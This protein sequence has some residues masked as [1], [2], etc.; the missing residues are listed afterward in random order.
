[1]ETTAPK[2]EAEPVTE[3]SSEKRNF[4]DF[5]SMLQLVIDQVLGIV[6]IVQF[7]QSGNKNWYCFF[8]LSLIIIIILLL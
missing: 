3:D 6:I 4:K 7:F 1:M 5:I 8:F 2:T